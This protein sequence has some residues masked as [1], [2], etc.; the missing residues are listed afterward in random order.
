MELRVCHWCNEQDMCICVEM[1]D[2]DLNQFRVPFCKKCILTS[3]EYSYLER[4][5]DDEIDDQP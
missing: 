3:P 4:R 2:E 5:F 1:D